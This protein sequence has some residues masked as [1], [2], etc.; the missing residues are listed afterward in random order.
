[1]LGISILDFKFVQPVLILHGVVSIGKVSIEYVLRSLLIPNIALE[2]LESRALAM[3][4]L[5]EI[6]ITPASIP[7]ITI[8]TSSSIN[9]NDLFLMLF[10]K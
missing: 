4:L 8:T 9:V 7:M 6:V 2:T 5:V 10:Y 3:L 1:M